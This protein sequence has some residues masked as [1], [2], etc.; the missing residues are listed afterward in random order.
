ML[1]GNK[2]ADN[3]M[4]RGIRYYD[5]KPLLSEDVHE[6]SDTMYKKTAYIMNNLLGHGV[7]NTPSSRVLD[8][9]VYLNEPAV[10]LING[11]IC[12]I[13]SSEGSPI[14]SKSKIRDANYASGSICIIGWY[15][16]IDSSYTKMR[17]YGGIDN[18]T[19][20]QDLTANKF[21]TEI[22]TRYQF[23][24]MPILLS[25]EDIS[26]ESFNLSIMKRDKEG[27]IIEGTHSLLANRSLGNIFI[28]NKPSEM[29]YSSLDTDPYLY[30]VPI[31]KYEYDAESSTI[32]I[33]N[34]LPLKPKGT[35]G[36]IRSEEEPLGEYIEGTSWYNPITREFKTYVPG[37]GFVESASKMAFLQYQSVYTI[38]QNGTSPTLPIDINELTEDDILQVTYEGL[39]LIKDEHYTVDYES[40][41]ITL[42]AGFSVNAGEKV[43]FTVTKIVEA[44]DIT[45]ITALFTTHMATTSSSTKEGHV[46]LSDA[47]DNTLDIS[48]GVAATPKAVHESK[49]IIDD[50]TN[51]KYHFGIENGL[52]YI[53]EG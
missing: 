41:T 17:D 50:A 33:N 12:L 44:N 5:M 21:K 26:S 49:F 34:Y 37:E 15:Q 31:L 6:F 52:L 51:I 48:S 4:Y 42:S 53:E 23:R 18:N 8:D 10:I 2:Y 38:E 35:S 11:D 46:K 40:H 19:I 29:V 22:S 32:E 3:K 20:E 30:I 36:F 13:Q 39:V 45:S 24:W 7:L 9:G 1:I 28:A 27:D 14:I 43:T 25:N 16:H 47:I